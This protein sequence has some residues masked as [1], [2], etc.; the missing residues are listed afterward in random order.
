MELQHPLAVVTPTLDGDVLAALAQADVAFTT[1]QLGRLIPPK[2]GDEARSAEGI[3]KVLQRLVRQGVVEAEQV[4]RAYQ[5]RL[6]REHLSAGPIVA[7]ANQRAALLHRLEDT[8]RGWA[9]GPTY[10]A[11]FGSAARGHMHPE[12]DIDLFLVRPSVVP[13]HIWE[14][15]T[16]KLALA[17]TRWTGNDTRILDLT[18][19]EVEASSGAGDPILQSIASEGITV[20]GKAGWLRLALAAAAVRA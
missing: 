8:L 11:L 12:S 16:M 14:D 1:S 18:E 2:G 5:Y 20:L 7:L 9:P 4:G 3:R 17:V 13:E 15:Q 10:A 19:D 6:N